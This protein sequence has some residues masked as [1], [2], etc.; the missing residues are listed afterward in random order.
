MRR[1]FFIVCALLAFGFSSIAGQNIIHDSSLTG[2]GRAGSPLGIANDG[3]KAAH[4]E[5]GVVK[6]GKIANGAVTTAKIDDGAVTAQ[7]LAAGAPQD[8]QVLGFDGRELVWKQV[9]SPA[10]L[11]IVD[12]AGKTV[13][14]PLNPEYDIDPSVF[15]LVPKTQRLIPLRVEV[16]GF[17]ELTTSPFTT[18]FTQANCS[19]TSFV[20]G[21]VQTYSQK[22]YDYGAIHNGNLYYPTG[23]FQDI[24]YLSWRWEGQV[25]APICHNLYQQETFRLFDYATISISSLGFTPPFRLSL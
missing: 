6:T 10:S 24:A 21:P 12:S 4:L 3:V 17:K 13:G 23:A 15:V 25:P 9:L 22:F 19:G 2:T 14:I 20:A 8:G 11:R 1:D 16:G 5:Q 18:I 7:K